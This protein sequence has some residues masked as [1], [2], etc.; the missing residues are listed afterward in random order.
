VT[1]TIEYSP[2]LE[3]ADFIPYGGNYEFMYC[4]DP[5]VI[6]E[7]AAETGKT[8][9]ACWKSHLLCTKYSG[10]Q[11]AIV[12][13]TQTSIY[14]SVLQ[15]FERVI[16]DSPVRKYGGEKPEKYVY[17]NGSVI[18]VGGMDNRDRVLS[19]ERDFIQACQTEEFSVDDWEYLTTR[20]TGRGSVIPH[21]QLYG[22]CNPAG[23]LHWIRQRSKVGHL[24]L[25]HTTHRD[26]PT[27]YDPST[28]EL[29]RQGERTMAQLAALT[30]VRR[31]RL[32]EG[33]WATAEGAVYDQFD[34]SVHVKV[35]SF[36]EMKAWYLA[37]DEG[38]TNPAVILL[39]GEDSDGRTHT[40]KEWY[41]RGKLQSTVVEKAKEFCD[42]VYEQSVAYY[43]SLGDT[44]IEAK[45][46]ALKVSLV[47][48]D[49][50]AAGLVAELLDAGLPAIGAKGRVLDG[51]QRMQDRLKVQ[52]DGLPRES[53]DP[54]CIN[55]I[56][57]YESYVWKKVTS[58]GIVKDEPQKENDHA[59]DA[60]RYLEELIGTTKTEMVDISAMDW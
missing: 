2:D 37:M 40:F 9:A 11:G 53:V 44:E 15:T 43:L 45:N 26:N 55:T 21:P 7:G 46:K 34:P 1:Y 23:S 25:I 13:K 18:W 10:T 54:S 29:T 41:E 14:G 38:Y 16:A 32:F 27:L 17:P 12:R 48:V 50:A 49:A 56:N 31:K 28:G 39:V 59:M 5:E 47:S 19:S 35:R 58:T 33:I 42:W 30:G 4:H 36:S 60:R 3:V 6:L 8:L 57:E 22:D 51:I 24:T 52:G 20:T